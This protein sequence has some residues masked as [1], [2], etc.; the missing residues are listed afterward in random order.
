MID[1][2]GHINEVKSIL[3]EHLINEKA[4]DYFKNDDFDN[5][6]TERE[7]SIKKHI[8]TKLDL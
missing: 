4:F 7:K 5:F 2:Y 8:I 3:K 1:K 6:I